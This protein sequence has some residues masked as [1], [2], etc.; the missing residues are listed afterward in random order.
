MP[1]SIPSCDWLEEVGISCADP[2]RPVPY[3]SSSVQVA[4]V[5][6]SSERVN[7]PSSVRWRDERALLPER[8]LVASSFPARRSSHGR[9]AWLPVNDRLGKK[10][11]PVRAGLGRDEDAFHHLFRRTQIISP[12]M[13]SEHLLLH[14]RRPSQK[15]SG[16]E[17]P[18]FPSFRRGCFSIHATN[19][20]K[21]S[22]F[23]FHL[24]P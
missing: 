15:S 18:G 8:Q 21:R 24:C 3:H 4:D 23:I 10:A 11:L 17:L 12:A 22:A 1:K 7:P 14:P 6:P 19:S 5:R 13:S 20:L 9:S 16:R 2:M